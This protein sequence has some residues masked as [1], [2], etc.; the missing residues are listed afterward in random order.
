M[1]SRPDALPEA[2]A[3][4]DRL[5]DLVRL[6]F[7]EPNPAPIKHLLVA[8]RA[9]RLTGTASADDRHQRRPDRQ[10]GG[11]GDTGNPLKLN[12]LP[13]GEWRIYIFPIRLC[14]E[15]TL[16]STS[17]GSMPIARPRSRPIRAIGW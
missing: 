4:W 8:A 9:D 14:G 12:L 2:R 10:V 16:C 5:L 13:I 6:L 17:T 7:A 3:C 11:V 1:R 15:K